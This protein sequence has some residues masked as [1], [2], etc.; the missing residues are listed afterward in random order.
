MSQTARIAEII[1]GGLRGHLPN[2]LASSLATDLAAAID[3]HLKSTPD[4]GIRASDN[5]PDDP[6][7]GQRPVDEVIAETKGKDAA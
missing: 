2:T 3:A 7:N 4:Q 6:F 5:R 1:A